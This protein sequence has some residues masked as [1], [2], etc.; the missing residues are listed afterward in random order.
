MPSVPRAIHRW[1]SLGPLHG[2]LGIVKLPDATLVCFV[3]NL[4]MKQW[5][6]LLG[7]WPIFVD[8][9]KKSFFFRSV[10]QVASVSSEDLS[11]LNL[12]ESPARLHFAGA[13]HR[14]YQV[15]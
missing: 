13:I 8:Q 15:L 1:F 9:E 14:P 2:L 4:L 5:W 10:A 7:G 11:V 3:E 12:S 6:E